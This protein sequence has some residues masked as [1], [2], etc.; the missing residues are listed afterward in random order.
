MH[1]PGIKIKFWL[2]ITDNVFR[3]LKEIIPGEFMNEFNK[4]CH[5]L[6]FR[7]T[8]KRNLFNEI[9]CMRRIKLAIFVSD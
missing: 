4:N 3:K 5:K 9:L 7:I 8:N 2:N 6:M 1:T